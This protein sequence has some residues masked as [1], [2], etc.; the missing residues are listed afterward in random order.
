[1]TLLELLAHLTLLGRH[2]KTVRLNSLTWEYCLH[3][4]HGIQLPCWR[5][6]E[7]DGQCGKHN[8]TCFHACPPDPFAVDIYDT[9]TETEF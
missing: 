6:S 3:R 7:Y 8:T 4:S 1:M 2:R 5:W 9:D